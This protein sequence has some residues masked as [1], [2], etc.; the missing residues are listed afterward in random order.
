MNVSQNPRKFR[1]SWRKGSI[2]PM[3]AI[4][5]MAI[6]G[7]TA[8]AVDIGALALAKTQFQMAADAASFAGARSLN[9]NTKDDFSKA[10]STSKTAALAA[11]AKHKIL[12]KLLQPNEI[13]TKVGH[14]TYN[15]NLKKF[16]LFL[17]GNGNKPANEAWSAVQTT[18][19]STP[20]NQFSKVF[21]YSPITLT[22]QSTAVHR[23]RDIAIVLD[24]SGSMRFGSLNGYPWYG[25]V[26]GSMNADTR[27]PKFGG[28]SH[29]AIANRMFRISPYMDGGGDVM[30]A[31]NISVETSGGPPLVLDFY[32][33]DPAGTYT[34]AF[35]REM[36]TYNW[37]TQPDQFALPAP[38]SF[39]VQSNTPISFTGLMGSD[40]L[41]GDRW[42]KLNGFNASFPN[43]TGPGYAF[44]PRQYLTGNNTIQANSH[45]K[46][47]AFESSGYPNFQGFT[48]GP[49]YYGKTF[50]L[51][52]PDPRPANDWRKKFFYLGNTTT[53]LDDNSILWNTNGVMRSAANNTYRI[54]Y[55]AVISWILSGPRV[56]PS[57]LRAGRVL[58]YSSIP[59]NI[60]ES[61]GTPDQRFWRAYIDYVIGAANSSE[62]A[63]HLYGTNTATNGPAGNN[64]ITPKSSLTTNLVNRP[65][66]HYNDVPAF[67]V[68]H[69][70]FGPISLIDFLSN[71]QTGRNWMPGT[72]HE[73]ATWQLKAGV[74]SALTDMQKNHP[75]DQAALIY[76]SSLN[77]YNL[78]RVGLGKDFTRMKNSL[79]YPYSLLD[80]LSD[81]NAEIRPYSSN[82]YNSY[83][84]I[85]TGSINEAASS[86]G[87]IPNANGGT[88][89]EMAFMV[90]YNQ[91]GSSG[92]FAGRV[93][94]AKMIIFETDGRPTAISN[95][96]FSPGNPN[97]HSSSFNSINHAG[98][99]SSV[100][101]GNRALGRLQTLCNLPT[102]NQPGFSSSKNPVRAHAIAFG[103]LFE[104]GNTSQASL[105]AMNFLVEVQRIG[106]TLPPS[107]TSIED[108]KIITGT[109]SERIEKL[110]NAFERILQSGVQITLIQ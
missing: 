24:F 107:A 6:L 69:F 7:M 8:L 84:A 47:N 96:N 71:Y 44:T 86:E 53:P 85:N 54:N 76:F 13:T 63:T 19:R 99:A 62:T 12:N 28:W 14:Y 70:W 103:Y 17:P 42:P 95:G 97:T 93:G 65:Y 29:A 9:D 32:T 61:G 72:A 11:T 26:Q 50:F 80:S 27:Y 21:N 41:G 73:T 56:F 74:Q 78:A 67:P 22:A 43:N 25:N 68:G 92:N 110:R 10:N 90:A 101:A 60:P 36:S 88:C 83:L 20:P 40:G 34:S 51:W 37:R 33:R 16:E 58:Y 48:L 23:P 109:A 106:K 100:A 66:M 102:S 3:I 1:N 31:S 89:P 38:E 108:F 45:A 4:S 98:G 94:A 81:S 18:I 30:A 82:F 77:N 39:D 104:P 57:N 75:N 64:R 49:G 55:N 52:P 79:F 2:L 46:N 105:E 87:I 5:L 15:T 91:L 35:F 59:T